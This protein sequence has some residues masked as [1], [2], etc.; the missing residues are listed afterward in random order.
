MGWP[1]VASLLADAE[2]TEMDIFVG[3]SATLC[4]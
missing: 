1:K 2:R 3:I 4:T